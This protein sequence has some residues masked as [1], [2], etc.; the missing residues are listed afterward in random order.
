MKHFTTY[1]GYIGMCDP[2]EV[3]QQVWSQ[4]ILEAIRKI[5]SQKQRPSAER[6]C[7]AIRQHHNYHEDVIG[8]HL[9]AAVKEGVVLKVFNKGQSS[10]KDPGGIQSILRI[11]QG[12]DITKVV[13]KAVR[14]LGERDGSS[15]KSIEKHIRHSHTI[16]ESNECDLKSAI[17]TAIK[18]ALTKNTIVQDGKNF[19]YNYNHPSTGAKRKSEG[20]RRSLNQEDSILQPKTPTPLPICSECLGTE[21]KN[22]NGVFEKLSACF[23]CGALVHL[24]CTSKEQELSTLLVKGGKWFCE[25]CK[26]C[27]GCGNTGISMCLLCCCSCDRKYHMGCLDPPAEK[28]PK[29]PWRC[30]HCLN[31]HDNKNS[32]KPGNGVRRKLDKVREKIKEKNQKSKDVGLTPATVPPSAKNDNIK[33]SVRKNR[34]PPIND[35]DKSEFENISNTNL[36]K[37][38]QENEQLDVN[39]KMSKEKQKF[40]RSSAFNSE[41]KK[42]G[43]GKKIDKSSKKEKEQTNNGEK[44]KNASSAKNKRNSKVQN[45]EK[46]KTSTV[47][48]ELNTDLKAPSNTNEKPTD[49]KEQS[50]DEDSN[51][52]SSEDSSSCVS[53]SDSETDSSID[54]SDS[55]TSMRN[56]KI[57]NIFNT[58]QKNVNTFGGMATDEDKPWGFA[59]A[60]AEAKQKES[61]LEESPTKKSKCN[62]NLFITALKEEGL[63]KDNAVVSP[64]KVDDISSD[65]SQKTPGFG[66]LKG[67]FDGLSHLFAAPS[68]SRASRSQ[69]NYN[70]NRRKPKD[71]KDED[72]QI[73]EK[74]PDAVDFKETIE[75]KKLVEPTKIPIQL[76]PLRADAI[77]EPDTDTR[78]KPEVECKAESIPAESISEPKAENSTSLTPSNLVKTAVNSKQHEKRKLIKSENQNVPISETP[79]TSQVKTKTDNEP[80]S[81]KKRNQNVANPP[82]VPYQNNSIIDIKNI[83]LAPGVTQKDVELFKEARERAAEATAALLPIPVPPKVEVALNTSNLGPLNAPLEIR[84]PSAIEF[85]KYEIKTW[86]SSPFPQEY[87]RLPKLFL[88]EFCL[89]YTKSKAVLER[90]QDKCTWRHPPATEIYRCNDLSVF[91]VDGNV[92]KIYC[93]N[94]CLLAKL[95]LDHKTLYYDVEPFLFYVLTKN[96]KKGCHLVGYFSKEKHCVQKYNVSCIMTMPQY[97][98]QG[99]GRFLIDFSYLLSK[100][101]GQPGTPEKPLSDLGKVSYYAY[102]KSVILEYLYTH[103]IA[104]LKLT[105]ISRDTGMYC[106]DISLALQLLGFIKLVPMEDGVSRPVICVDWKKVD[107]HMERVRN[108][109]TRIPIDYECLRWTPLVTQPISQLIESKPEDSPEL[110]ETANIIV[111]MPEKIIIEAH[112]GVKLKRGRKRKIS[113]TSSRVNKSS[114][115]EVKTPLNSSSIEGNENAEIEI[116]SSGRKRTR[117]SKFNETTFGDIKP[118]NQDNNKRK[119]I[120]KVTS[121]KRLK[122]DLI[123]EK[124]DEGANQQSNKIPVATRGNNRSSNTPKTS[125]KNDT[126]EESITK[127]KKTSVTKERILGERWSQRRVKK[128]QEQKEKEKL[129][130]E[131]T[132]VEN[133]RAKSESELQ[134]TLK[135]TTK[136]NIE[137][138][139]QTIGDVSL[140]TPQHKS[141]GKRMR[142]KRGW[143]KAKTRGKIVKQLTLHEMIKQNL[144]KDSESESLISEKSDEETT[145]EPANT[146]IT[147]EKEKIKPRK[148]DKIKRTSRISTEEDSSAEADDEMENDELPVQKEISPV[149]KFKYTKVSPPKEKLDAAQKNVAVKDDKTEKTEHSQSPLY[150]TTSESEMEIDGQKIKTISHREVFKSGLIVP[151]IKQTDLT[152]NREHEVTPLETVNLDHLKDYSQIESGRKSTDMELEKFDDTHKNNI[153]EPKQNV[154]VVPEKTLEKMETSDTPTVE[155]PGNRITKFLENAQK[156]LEAVEETAPISPPVQENA[157]SQNNA[158]E[159]NATKDDINFVKSQGESDNVKTNDKIYEGSNEDKQVSEKPIKI[160]N[161]MVSNIPHQTEKVVEASIVDSSAEPQIPKQKSDQVQ[162]PTQLL[163]QI[164]TPVNCQNQKQDQSTQKQSGFIVQK[165]NQYQTEKPMESPKQINHQVSKNTTYI[166]QNEPPISKF[167]PQ[168]QKKN[169]PQSKPPVYKSCDFHIK[170]T[171]D[172]PVDQHTQK[173]L[174]VSVSPLNEISRKTIDVPLQRSAELSCQQPVDLLQRS[175]QQPLEVYQQRP[176]EVSQ[177]RQ[178]EISQ[179][180]PLE[181]SQQLPLEVSQQR[182]PEVSQQRLPEVSQQRPLEVSQQRPPEVSQQRPSEVFQQRPPEVS[183]QRPPE[184]SQQRPPEVSQQRPPEVSQQRLPE[185]SQQRLPEVSQQRLPDI[186][187]HRLPEVSQLRPPEVSYQRPSEVSQ[188]RSSEGF[189]QR[190]VEVPL[191][192]PVE[193]RPMDFPSLNAISEESNPRKNT[194]SVIQKQVR[195]TTERKINPDQETQKTLKSKPVEKPQERATDHKLSVLQH[196]PMQT[197]EM[198]PPEKVSS[199]EMKYSE[200]RNNVHADIKT[201]EHHD[202]KTKIEPKISPKQE[203]SKSESRKEKYDEKR[204]HQKLH[205]EKCMYEAQQKMHMD[206]ES[207]LANAMTE[208]YMTQAQYHW[209]WERLWGKNIYYDNKGYTHPML[210]QFAPL[211]MLPKQP[212]C[213]KEKSKSHRYSSQ[214]SSTSGSSSNKK[215]SSRSES[216]EKHSSPKKEDKKLRHEQESS[217][218]IKMESSKSASCSYNQNLTKHSSLSST[219][220][221]SDRSDN[222]TKL[223]RKEQKIEEASQQLANSIK[224]SP[225]TAPTSTDITS[226]YTADSASSSVHGLHYGHCGIDVNQLN[227]ETPATITADVNSQN[228]VD[229]VRPTTAVVQN[230][231]Q[232]PNYDCT[233]QH[234]LQNLQTTSISA[235]SP[236]VPQNN[237]QLVQNQNSTQQLHQNSSSKR[238]VQ[239][240]RS[241]R[242]NTPS[243]TKQ[244]NVSRSTPPSATQNRQRATPPCNTQQLQQMQVSPTAQHTTMQHQHHNSQQLQPHL[245]HQVAV[246]QGYQYQIGPSAVHQHPHVHHHAVISQANYIPLAVTT[247]AFPSTST[248]VNIPPMTTVIQHGMS[249]TPQ[250]AASPLNSVGATNQKLAPSPSCAV[251]TGTNFYIQTN[252]HNHSTTPS[253][254]QRGN[255]GGQPASANASSSIAKLQQ[256]TNGLDMTPAPSCQ[257]MTPPPATMTLTPPP[258]HLHATPPP[259]H[260]MVQNQTVRNLTPPSGLPPNLQQQVLGYHKYYQTNMNVNQLSGTV[261]PPIGQNLGRTS[262]NSTN[263]ATM[264]HMQTYNMNSYPM[265]TQQTPGAV[266]SYIANTGFINN[267]IPMQMMNMAQTQYQDPAALQR[268]Q[269]QMYRTYINGMLQPLNSTMRR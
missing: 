166:T 258:T 33:T 221:L 176:T 233:V 206:S 113:L 35:S 124:A 218:T 115:L 164:Q 182:P 129:K 92:N 243:S 18:R 31:H 217:S 87:A 82:A 97:Q 69:P 147:P 225:S 107:A 150:T 89:K 36:E 234:T 86:Y 28:K 127:P 15:M 12:S 239:Q 235:T 139:S 214:S 207:L 98:R 193:Q 203:T 48:S 160:P 159:K 137:N 38:K 117:P 241:N 43:I 20:T 17:N 47:N 230:P 220:S 140:N 70:P 212:T 249:S 125:V 143:G 123:V 126:L 91:E 7:H 30:K 248:C 168:T 245:H 174:D 192:R 262:R 8:E 183:Q 90:H 116:T 77:I 153:I 68:E 100:E 237:I 132:N 247:Q 112:S 170:K 177:Q 57:P 109:K 216:R 171:S 21:T 219:I 141:I 108:S 228:S 56:I 52:S 66:Q 178:L 204:Y 37:T 32:K 213:E 99:F 198:K 93:Q 136:T 194:E 186:S 158:S 41:K 2:R 257:I 231:T 131:E 135:V 120:E 246:H 169:E 208:N 14:E 111:P 157:I 42:D 200:S 175:L 67:L 133:V 229:T 149:N 156:I 22:R 223:E 242:S 210:H 85:G 263:V 29:C 78:V 79:T 181:V 104:K 95:F 101:E 81:M 185:I 119:L 134:E 46:N 196:L 145:K 58:K 151:H 5:R 9:E 195:Q 260:Q 188:Q 61:K 51:D 65:K 222:K 148:E 13:A 16:E 6:I 80:R 199:R 96:D 102:W 152:I 163:P 146:P 165:Q 209:Q 4:W 211:D 251:T 172:L 54:N 154:I 155:N 201:H 55:K 142:K 110:K 240:Q 238:Q 26:T 256:L 27:D 60:A 259:P 162:T 267:Q 254:S 75:E 62:E 49:E 130:I 63:L 3:S 144:Q 190:S 106:Q 10:Y 269:P 236:T 39:D 45:S 268:A 88:C 72:C 94:L 252:P 73:E 74:K 23:E 180:R 167:D 266:T 71:A 226:I 1:K 25:E 114:K 255:T 189:Q 179:Q 122:T 202:S 224:Q 59:A 44:L 205:E 227:L 84:C 261:T 83:H 40:F 184:V 34:V 197:Q 128:Q 215:E 64:T 187:Q 19:K 244:H 76:S 11:E 53:C 232:Q 121:R 105:E 161:D 173:S 138:T 265:P 264:Q 103:R 191:Q 250:N 118:K 24:S 253:P 50:E